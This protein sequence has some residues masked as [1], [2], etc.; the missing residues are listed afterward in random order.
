MWV[1]SEGVVMSGYVERGCIMSA[2]VVR[3]C[4][5]RRCVVD[6]VRGKEPG[7]IPDDRACVGVL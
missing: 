7:D 4:A 3:G 2:C 6:W 5:M 1:K